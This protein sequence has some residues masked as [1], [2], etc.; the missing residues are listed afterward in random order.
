MNG[1]GQIAAEQVHGQ[2]EG[3]DH[4]DSDDHQDD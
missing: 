2:G 4:A 1:A 3:R